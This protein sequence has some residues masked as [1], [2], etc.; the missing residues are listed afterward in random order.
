MQNARSR[1]E[2]A[3]RVE[4]Q[5]RELGERPDVSQTMRK[6]SQSSSRNPVARKVKK[7][8]TVVTLVMAGLALA[9][10][11]V[12]LAGAAAVAAGGFWVHSQLNDPTATVQGFYSSLHQQ[13]YTQAYSYLSSAEQHRLSQ[14][15]FNDQYGSF[16]AIGGVVESY[17]ILSNTLK[18]TSATITVEVTRRNNAS[19]A[20]QQTL[21]LVNENNGWHIDS[22]VFGALVPVS[23]VTAP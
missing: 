7:P 10:L 22:I 18:S 14:E 21:Y 15:A 11:V 17:P 20:Q 12:C 5:R 1:E 4:R 23:T 8:S 9:A 16:D 13:D 3:E 2:L 19:S 6:L